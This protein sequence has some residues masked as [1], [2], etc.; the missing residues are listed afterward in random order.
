MRCIVCGKESEFKICGSCFVERNTL[1]SLPTLE[2]EKCGKC[3]SFRFGKE[4]VRIDDMSAV[5]KEVFENLAVFPDFNLESVEI[6][7]NSAI[8]TGTIYGDHVSVT[9]PLNLRIRT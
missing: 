3:G 2:I 6:L 8:V 5:E 1:V 7:K 4:W 9:I